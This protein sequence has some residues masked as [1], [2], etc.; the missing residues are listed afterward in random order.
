MCEQTSSS[1]WAPPCGGG[2]CPPAA[3]CNTSAELLSQLRTGRRHKDE[4]VLSTDLQPT[5]CNAWVGFQFP[6]DRIIANFG[7]AMDTTL[8][9]NPTPAWAGSEFH[10][11]LFGKLTFDWTGSVQSARLLNEESVEF[12]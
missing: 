1:G 4:L 3:I 11:A 8:L 6:F 9:D 10:R 7:Y 12:M 5:C 2:A